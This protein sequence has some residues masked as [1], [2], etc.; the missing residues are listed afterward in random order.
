MTKSTK[1]TEAR[2][3]YIRLDKLPPW[4]RNPKKHDIPTLQSSLM[5]FGW[6]YPVMLDEQSG[7]LLAGHGRCE[8]AQSLRDMPVTERV[9]KFGREIPERVRVD[10]DGQWLVPVLRG[11]QFASEREAEAYLLA[12]NRTNEIGGWDDEMLKAMLQDLQ[13]SGNDADLEGLGWDDKEINALIRATNEDRAKGLAPEEKLDGYL[14]A[15]IKHL[16]LFFDAE[17]Y[18]SVIARLERAMEHSKTE[19]HTDAF[20]AML[21]AYEKVNEL[22]PITTEAPSMDELPGLEG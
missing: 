19:T 7:R 11:I 18:D 2:L 17:S 8:T 4:P 12:D 20:L 15:A 14:G 10:A 16:Q 5:R 21:D 3:E 22:P 9:K 6:T 1:K 13:A